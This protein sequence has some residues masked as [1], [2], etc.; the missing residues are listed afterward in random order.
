MLF[1]S[2]S[3][4][5]WMGFID[6]DEYLEVKGNY[7]L[8]GMLSKL[9]KNETVGALAINWLNHNWGGLHDRPVGQGIRETFTQ[10][11]TDSAQVGDDGNSIIKSFMKPSRGTMIQAHQ[12]LLHDGMVTVGEN[13]NV[14]TEA[15]NLHPPSREKIVLHHYPTRSR[16]EYEVKLTRGDAC[17]GETPDHRGENY[18]RLL[19]EAPSFEC[20]EMAAYNP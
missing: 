5:K 14:V 16:T 6:T 13:G 17:F 7:T 8:H 19:A 18:W 1:R 20:P 11:I 10:C 3:Q 4:H 9:E 2:G 15:F 12:A